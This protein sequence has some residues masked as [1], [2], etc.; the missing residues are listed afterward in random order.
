[1][2]L[3]IFISYSHRDE[4][5][6]DELAKQLKPL[7]YEGLIDPWHDRKILP[8][9]EFE[10]QISQEIESADIILLLVSPDFVSSA[11]CWQKEMTRAMARHEAGE[12]R[13]IPVILRHADWY[14]SPF[15]KLLALPKDGLPVTKWSDRDEAFLSVAQGIRKIANQVTVQERNEVAQ[16]DEAHR[17]PVKAAMEPGSLSEGFVAGTI[18]LADKGAVP[19]Y[20]YAFSQDSGWALTGG[21]D[22][23]IRLWD[24]EMGR[25]HRLFEGHTKA[26]ESVAW[27]TDQRC[28][29]SAA[30]DHTVRLWDVKTGRC[31][32][33]FEGHASEVWSVAW[34]HDQRYAC[35]GSGDHS[36]RLWDVQMGTCVGVLEG[37]TDSVASVEWSPDQCSLVSSSED[38]SVRLWDVETRQC[39]RV[40]EGH[41]CPV[42]CAT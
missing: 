11:Y 5:L 26:V 34:S 18:Q 23:A 15:G 6:H 30:D 13:V 10:Q 40:L 12:A 37:H 36:V 31:L 35:S 22:K 20:S 32:R 14:S 19:V 7:E 21:R 24:L 39:L 8:G 41:D 28:A 1:M 17:S 4:G 16:P 29:L 25:C 9:D 3:K 27:S 42:Y 33:V 2:P 38:G